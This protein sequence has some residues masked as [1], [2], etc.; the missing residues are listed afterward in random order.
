MLHAQ[1]MFFCTAELLS[2][3]CG[4]FHRITKNMWQA[5]CTNWG[6]G[7]ASFVPAMPVAFDVLFQSTG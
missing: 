3:W 1:G 6:P 4:T 2:R 5:D 7:T